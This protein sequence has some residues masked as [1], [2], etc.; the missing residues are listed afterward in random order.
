MG[1]PPGPWPRFQAKAPDT[2]GKHWGILIC[3][4]L[5]NGCLFG[6][7]SM[8]TIEDYYTY[9]FPNYHPTRVVTLTYQPFV[10]STTAIFTYHEAKVNTR[11]RNLVGYTLF[12]L[13]SFAAIILDVATSGRGGIAP[14]AGVC[15]IAAAFGVADGHVQGGMTGDLSLMCPEFIQCMEPWMQLSTKQNLNNLFC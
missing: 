4:L 7:N 11:L 5:G 9:L 10:L 8:L 6:F 15:I 13:S 1:A 2:G 3:W 12:F 14:F